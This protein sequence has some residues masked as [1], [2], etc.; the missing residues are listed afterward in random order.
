MGI[1]ND[2]G[3]N[4]SKGYNTIS[5]ASK[6][7]AEQLKLKSEISEL[8][9]EKEAKFQILGQMFYSYKQYGGDEPD[10]QPIISEI[11]DRDSQI[12][13]RNNRITQLKNLVKCPNCGHSIEPNQRFCPSCGYDL[14]APK[15]QPV[16]EN[17]QTQDTSNKAKC[18]NC[19]QIIEPGMKFCRRCGTKLDSFWASQ[20][21][22]KSEEEKD[23]PDQMVCPNCGHPVKPG[24][25]FCMFCGQSLEA[26]KE[27]EGSDPTPT[28]SAPEAVAPAADMSAAEAS[29]DAEPSASPQVEGSEKDVES[30]DN[31]STEE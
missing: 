28:A 4:I 22:V 13:E 19:G 2:L 20:N 16:P 21:A 12:A 25:K 24:M 8:E 9:K 5:S 7:T 10:Y 6:E 26:P 23:S 18:P 11:A 15:M 1:F 14:Q 17:V 30:E 31:P 3:K 29:A 27:A